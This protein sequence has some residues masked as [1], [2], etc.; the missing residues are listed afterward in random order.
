MPPSRARD[1]KERRCPWCSR[2]F[3]KEDHLSRHIRSHTREKPFTCSVCN[4]AFSRHDS[5]LRHARNH[6]DT[7]CSQS[8]Q[9]KETSTYPG[10]EEIE[11][12]VTS[13]HGAN[14][15]NSLH[16]SVLLNAS[17]ES[18]SDRL[19]VPLL[20]LSS[21][22][23]PNVYSA[24][25][26]TNA[27]DLMTEKAQAA[28]YTYTSVDGVDKALDEQSYD[29]TLDLAAQV[30]TWLVTDDFDLEALNA[31]INASANPPELPLTTLAP[32]GNQ[33]T[34]DALPSTER[35]ED[36]V[37]RRW[38]TYFE[39]P[40]TGHVTPD[41]SE[42][43]Y[44]DERYRQRL[45]ENL[46]YRVPTDP[47]PSTDFLNMC[48]QMY[49]ARFNPIFPVVHAPTFRPSTQTSLLLLSICSIGSLFLGSRQGASHGTKMFEILNKATLASWEKYMTKQR[50]EIR[51]MTQSSLIGQIFAYLTGRPR[52]LLLVQTFHGTIITWA[53]RNSMFRS[54]QTDKIESEEIAR[55]PERAWMSWVAREEQSRL[56][57]GLSILDSEFAEIFL[58]EPFMRRRSLM[59]S[60]SDNEL[61]TATTAEDWLRILQSSRSNKPNKFRDYI[62]LEQIAASIQDAR[63]C[64]NWVS[65]APPLQAA[66]EEFHNRNLR[67]AASDGPDILCLEALWHATFLAWLVDFDRLELVVGREG[68]QESQ[69]EMPF[70]REWADSQDGCR[71]ALHAALI[72]RSLES[73]PIGNEPPI[74]APRVLYR[75]TLVWYC[76]LEFSATSDQRAAAQA[77]DFPELKH[78]GIDCERLLA[79]MNDFR[80]TRPKPLQSS[81]LCRCVDLLRHLG[82]WG[83]GRQLAAMWDAIL[84]ELPPR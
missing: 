34:C 52:D 44:V 50:S 64:D 36:L 18:S 12:T 19:D 43:A 30:P 20:A 42:S 2:S 38:F 72:L 80:P 66:L 17:T 49:F 22:T 60:I 81:I 4:K 57:A 68:Y 23:G 31:S 45:T 59:S 78:A 1:T 21:Y 3:A 13:L 71:C 54:R 55:D 73:L 39:T 47:L 25:T 83:L 61:W 15:S 37:C 26:E 7:D 79:E 6:G 10:S 69:A 82:H 63:T 53:R 24:T 14:V 77:L 75:A 74:H 56:V 84:Y 76:Y 51:S 9:G 40:N 62:E 65:A 11:S 70:V 33:Q 41:R 8:S 48:I 32:T 29:W 5:L 67:S 28:T 27:D 16:T 46:Q 35:F 58:T